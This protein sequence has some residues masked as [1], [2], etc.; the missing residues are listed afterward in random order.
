ME[1][2]ENTQEKYI[3][4]GASFN[5]PHM[6]HFSA[7]SQMLDTHDKIIIFPYPQKFAEGKIEELPPISQRI[8]MLQLF[9]HEFF[10][11]K[12]IHEK[13]IMVVNLAAEIQKQQKEELTEVL[14]K[15]L[16]GQSNDSVEK[17]V[18]HT[19]D[20]LKFVKNRMPEG[21]T[22][23][24]CLGFEAQNINRKEEF[25]NEE[26]IK[27]EFPHFFLEEETTIKSQDLR[28]FFSSHKNIKSKKDEQYIKA[29][30]GNSLAEFIFENNLYGVKKKTAQ[31]K[32]ETPTTRP[33]LR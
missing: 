31:S 28:D 16:T 18:L 4:Y 11:N 26:K 25:F 2:K 20:Y 27:E 29:C 14:F 12:K 21:F 33:K 1:N 7:I 22:L 23:S 13:K 32:T 30:V 3:L 5:P 10:P 6:G 17:K 8:K 9:I 24:A 19:Y 15:N